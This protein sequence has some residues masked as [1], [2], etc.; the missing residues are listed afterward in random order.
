MLAQVNY[1][2]IKKNLWNV[3]RKQKKML[4]STAIFSV[5]VPGLNITLKIEDIS[6]TCKSMADDILVKQ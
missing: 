1:T 2:K 3:L 6:N 5:P 4:H